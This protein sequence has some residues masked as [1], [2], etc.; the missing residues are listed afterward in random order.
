LSQKDSRWRA[1][2]AALHGDPDAATNRHPG[3]NRNG[4]NTDPDLI[5]P[6]DA[7]RRWGLLRTS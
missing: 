1:W 5:D 6:G 7:D 4:C 3:P 2:P